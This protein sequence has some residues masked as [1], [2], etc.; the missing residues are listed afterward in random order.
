M[1]DIPGGLLPWQA[2]QW[3]AFVDRFDQGRLAHAWL[4][5][6]AAGVGKLHFAKAFAALALCESDAS[7]AAGQPREACGYCQGCRLMQ[8]GSHPDYMLLSP[9][10]AGKAIKIDQIRQLTG[11][12][13]KT[14]LRQGRRVIIISPAE[15]M[16]HNAANALLKC[17]EEPAGDTIFLLVSSQLSLLLPTIRSRCQQLVFPVPPHETAK[18]W[19]VKQD[20][21]V[22][23]AAESLLEMAGGRPLL[24]REYA[25]KDIQQQQQILIDGL[26]DVSSGRRTPVEVAADWLDIPQDRLTGWMQQWLYQMVRFAAGSNTGLENQ[27]GGKML[28]YIAGKSGSKNLVQ[29]YDWLLQQNN[30][31]NRGMNLNRQLFC[32]QLLI[33]WLHL[34]V[35]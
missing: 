25:S 19:L 26:Q 21:V 24:A 9:E 4:L 20:T 14:A 35:R 17:L 28:V 11:F 22:S 31:M 34:T 29:L 6:G 5:R 10:Q 3:Q 30:I 2:E 18:D 16:N 13:E 15:Q 12:T 8:A 33:R 27:V 7:A 1:S 23:S 32:E